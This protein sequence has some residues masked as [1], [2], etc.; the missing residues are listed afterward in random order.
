MARCLARH[1]NQTFSFVRFRYFP[2]YRVNIQNL[3]KLSSEAQSDADETEADAFV[4]I[5]TVSWL[6]S[7]FGHFGF[8]IF[9]FIL[10]IQ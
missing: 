8:C 2:F 9:A 10:E 7:L 5:T 1:L 4:L 6:M 3:Y